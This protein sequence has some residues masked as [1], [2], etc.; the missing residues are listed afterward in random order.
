ML[1]RER[2][3]MGSIWLFLK[4]MTGALAPFSYLVL[5]YAQTLNFLLTHAGAQRA[6]LLHYYTLERLLRDKDSKL[7]CSSLVSLFYVVCY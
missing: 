3:N 1:E 4:G 7:E 6:R 2:E 5:Y